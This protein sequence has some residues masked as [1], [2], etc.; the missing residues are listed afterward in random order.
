MVIRPLN[1]SSH[2]LNTYRVFQDYLTDS[3]QQLHEVS[4]IIPFHRWGSYVSPAHSIQYM[5]CLGAT[6]MNGFYFQRFLSPNI[7]GGTDKSPL[8]TEAQVHRTDTFLPYFIVIA[9]D[10]KG[11]FWF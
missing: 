1:N 11:L 3:S 4:I 8:G 10:P 5:V 9:S 2:L 6:Q 7:Y